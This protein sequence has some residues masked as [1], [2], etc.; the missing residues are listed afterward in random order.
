M[1]TLAGYQEIRSRITGDAAE[2]KPLPERAPALALDARAFGWDEYRAKQ[3]LRAY[4]IPTC[5]EIIAVSVEA[6]QA[7]AEAIGYPVVVKGCHAEL[8]HKTEQGL[9][10]LGLATSA[11]VAAACEAVK[12]QFGEAALLV[13][14][15]VAGDREFIAGVNR[16]AGFPPCV[17][18]GLGG[19]WAEAIQDSAIRLAPLSSSE[20]LDQVAAI[21]GRAL[22]EARRGRPAVDREALADILVR[23]GR[24]A[25]DFPEIAEID[26]NP[27]VI[28]KG[29]PVVVDALFAN[30]DR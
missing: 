16:P 29:E 27:I 4:G 22:L 8:A 21:R 10:H 3:M 1:A 9:V 17:L 2:G 28:R 6:A 30:K 11:E 5:R 25:L 7:A 23:L 15:M 13:S 20:A 18:F 24:L 12:R 19:I 14:E 26:L